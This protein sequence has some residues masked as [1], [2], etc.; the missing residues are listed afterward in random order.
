MSRQAFVC[1]YHDLSQP[2][3]DCRAC[4]ERDDSLKRHDP[5][6]W[7]LCSQSPIFPLLSDP[8]LPEPEATYRVIFIVHQQ[9]FLQLGKLDGDLRKYFWYSLGVT[10]LVSIFPPHISNSQ[11]LG[12]LDQSHILCH[13]TWSIRSGKLE[14][15]QI[16]FVNPNAGHLDTSWP[17]HSPINP[18][19]IRLIHELRLNFN[20]LL[21]RA[22]IMMPSLLP[23]MKL[24]QES[25]GKEVGHILQDERLLRNT[26][27]A[28][29]Q[30]T[31]ATQSLTT[32][33]RLNVSVD[34]LVQ[35]NSA[36]AYVLSQSFYGG[37]PLV[38]NL[39]LNSSYSL[40]GTG[41]AIMA[42]QKLT[43]FIIDGFAELPLA[44]VI[45]NNYRDVTLQHYLVDENSHQNSKTADFYIKGA[46]R[47]E[48]TPKL[49]YFS[50]RMGFS[51]HSYCVTAATQSLASADA[52]RRNLLTLTHE[53]LHS[54]VKGRV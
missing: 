46:G 34:A 52:A 45:K 53:L 20:S 43:E 22:R 3:A 27:I 35:L 39:A 41:T 40:L 50:T 47:S 21:K 48:Q 25:V 1:L 30:L 24:V 49:A 12:A 42:I 15:P 44:T 26:T 23:V 37:P 28:K 7:I 4:I 13:E 2:H 31:D 10:S 14:K 17:E 5:N 19:L 54:H 38:Q 33:K 51:E 32:H 18:D 9:P 11:I 29:E 16:A 6:G 36:L 8:F